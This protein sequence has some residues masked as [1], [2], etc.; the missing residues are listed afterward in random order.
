MSATPTVTAR[1]APPAIFRRELLRHVHSDVVCDISWLASGL[2]ALPFDDGAG[3][4]PPSIVDT[5]VLNG[6]WEKAC[7]I[8]HN[9]EEGLFVESQLT[10]IS[11]IGTGF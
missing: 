11:Y 6:P 4:C 5:L 8:K 7:Q 9:A 10:S 1:L 3:Y 2:T